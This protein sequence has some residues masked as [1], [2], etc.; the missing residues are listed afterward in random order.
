[1]E[2]NENE[3]FDLVFERADKKHQKRVGIRHY[4]HSDCKCKIC[5]SH[6]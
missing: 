2:N 3:L 1:L 4:H 6:K 5:Q